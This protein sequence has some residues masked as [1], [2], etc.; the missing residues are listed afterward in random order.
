MTEEQFRDVRNKIFDAGDL[1][2]T[3][4]YESAGSNWES[5]KDEYLTLDQYKNSR[6]LIKST[7]SSI[8]ESY[9]LERY[10]SYR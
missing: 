8:A 3:Y 2:E 1:V 4:E 7:H 9:K 6:R 5:I 10:F